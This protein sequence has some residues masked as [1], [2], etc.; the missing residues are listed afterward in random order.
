MA[1]AL[2]AGC[3]GKAVAITLKHH[4]DNMELTAAGERIDALAHRA[5]AGASEDAARFAAFTHEKD[6]DSARRLLEA[7]MSLE[8]SAEDLLAV[9]ARI[10]A[11]TDSVV[12]AD[13][14]AA[15]ALCEAFLTIERANLEENRREAAARGAHVPAAGDS[16]RS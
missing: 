15:R 16:P 11:M 6:A 9:L 8:Q 13:I 1:L 12:A 7:G 10:E 2:A 14:G 5:L 3:A 4:P